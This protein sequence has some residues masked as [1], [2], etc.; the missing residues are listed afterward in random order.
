MMGVFAAVLAAIGA[1]IHRIQWQRLIL[2]PQHIIFSTS[3]F[4]IQTFGLKK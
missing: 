4:E 3:K 1:V 2:Q